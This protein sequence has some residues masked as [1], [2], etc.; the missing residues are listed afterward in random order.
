[1]ADDRWLL[2]AEAAGFIGKHG[3]RLIR[4]A[5]RL[6]LIPL[7]GVRA[8]ESEPVEIPFSETGPI[9]CEGS[10]IGDGLL[11]LWR[12]VMMRWEDA[13]QV[14]Q[15]DVN[16]LLQKAQTPPSSRDGA[17]NADILEAEAGPLVKAVAL[18]LRRIFHEGRPR[19]L[20]RNK[21][22]LRVC[23]EAGERTDWF[24]PSTLDRA[25]AL[26]WP[27]PKRSRVPKAAKQPR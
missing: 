5:R 4:R 26:A 3:E 25:V 2:L 12:D 10:R 11:T 17:S 21:I 6:K 13:K 23:K 19:G 7:R 16:R 24:S 9:D 18:V 14:A 15:L 8:G 27:R 1:M 22:M 20:T